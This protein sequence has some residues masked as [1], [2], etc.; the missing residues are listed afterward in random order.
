MK[1]IQ[2]VAAALFVALL[3][4]QPAWAALKV[5]TS[6][7]T[8]L[9]TDLNS[10]FSQLSAGA[11]GMGTALLTNAMVSASAAIAHSKLATPALI[12]KAQAFVG[13]ACSSSPCTIDDGSGFS[14]ITRTS[15]GLYVGTYS[16]TLT[17][18]ATVVITPLMNQ[19]A[20]ATHFYAC[21]VKAETTTTVTFTCGNADGSTAVEDVAFSIVVW[22]T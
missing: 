14:G 12:P 18:T 21:W 16:S 19:P 2:V 5:W 22:D 11:V 4:A 10:N 15:T 7:E 13:T 20:D 8:V 1:K 17:A 6:H 3:C 9:S